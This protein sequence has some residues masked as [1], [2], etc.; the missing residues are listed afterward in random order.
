MT[1]KKAEF[2]WDEGFS[3]QIQDGEWRN[4]KGTLML[5]TDIGPDEDLD[6]A[7]R[8]LMDKVKAIVKAE[9]EAEVASFLNGNPTVDEIAEALGAEVVTAKELEA[10][11]PPPPE[12][13]SVPID[14]NGNEKKFEEIVVD[15][16]IVMAKKDGEKYAKAYNKKYHKFGVTVWP[17]VMKESSIGDVQEHEVGQRLDVSGGPLIGLGLKG[18]DSEY[19][20][21]IIEWK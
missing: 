4:G 8:Q 3:K 10:P 18:E 14:E 16:F 15:Y 11:V 1:Y 21:K 6:L 2:Q 7:V 17:E 9:V 5:S 12:P 19:A 20:S 13:V